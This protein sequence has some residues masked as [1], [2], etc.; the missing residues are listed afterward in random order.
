MKYGQKL[1]KLF[2]Q[3]MNITGPSYLTKIAQQGNTF[4][5]YM[6]ISNYFIAIVRLNLNLIIYYFWRKMNKVFSTLT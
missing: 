3:A 1:Y 6:Q 2:E 5:I 4:N